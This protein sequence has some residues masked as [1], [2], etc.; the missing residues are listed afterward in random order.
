MRF[1]VV[2]FLL[3]VSSAALRSQSADTYYV[4]NFGR[5][6]EVAIPSGVLNRPHTLI[7]YDSTGLVKQSSHENTY[8]I[9]GPTPVQ[10]DLNGNLNTSNRFGSPSGHDCYEI[11][12]GSDSSRYW[13]GSS[14]APNQLPFAIYNV[15]PKAA[16]NPSVTGGTKICL[17]VQDDDGNNLYTPGERLF[18]VGDLSLPVD[19]SYTD[20]VS[21]KSVFPFSLSRT[22]WSSM[23]TGKSTVSYSAGSFSVTADGVEPPAG[24]VIRMIAQSAD[25]CRPYIYI[26]DSLT[27]NTPKRHAYPF[28]WYSF[29][30]PSIQLL[31]AP[32]GMSLSGD[33][34]IWQVDE[35]QLGT[36]HTFIL[37]VSNSYGTSQKSLTA[38]AY[39]VYTQ[40]QAVCGQ[41]SP[42]SLY[43]AIGA[44]QNLTTRFALA[45]NRR[46]VAEWIK[47][48][49]IQIGYPTARLDSFYLT[50]LQWPFN[51]GTYY[52]QWNYN[53]IAELPGSV[54]PDSVYI[55]GGHHDNILYPYSQ[56][57][58]FAGC[59]GADDN[60]SGTVAAIEVA[61]VFQKFNYQPKHT[62]KFITFA[63]EEF[64][65]YGS[66]DY[67]QKAR[68]A[69]ERIQMMINN[70]MIS[71][72][73]DTVNYW[74]AYLLGY[75]NSEPVTQLA[76]RV[77]EQ[78]TT[79]R[80]YQVSNSNSSGSDSRSFFDQGYKTFYFEEYQFSPFY[81]SQDDLLANCNTRYMAE[82]VKA[83][84]AMLMLENGLNITVSADEPIKSVHEFALLPNYP[85]PFNPA[86]TIRY[87]LPENGKVT[88]KIYNVLG[89]EIRS[90]VNANQ[91]SGYHTVMWDGRSNNGSAVSSGV[92]MYRLETGKFAKSMKMVLVR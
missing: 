82:I 4:K 21:L 3:S 50:N 78:Y 42:D 28:S 20:S 66:K 79:F 58:P 33:T 69:N 45:P 72:C 56:G 71:T 13:I 1:Y 30:T 5:I 75:T 70:D 74:R 8:R 39:P 16:T 22:Y 85:N 90:L 26:Q 25:T 61:R 32:A 88:L 17:R 84:C 43:D 7:G 64:G 24:T 48:K 83:A 19:S 54:E 86:T 27:A 40:I 65:L 81:H 41:I 77:V 67:A 34:V 36:E 62:I 46:D 59:P 53:V 89:Q 91:V 87:Q 9:F 55:L 10:S 38:K 2:L 6:A 52:P 80:G 12:Y 60:A 29:E 76:Q 47:N 35:S 57:D 73:Q 92:Y 18:V 51:S 11:R 15:G 31:N 23:R 37:S 49:F 68:S 44:L 63:A 14:L